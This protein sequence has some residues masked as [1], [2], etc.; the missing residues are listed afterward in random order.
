MRRSLAALTLLASM[1]FAAYGAAA[2]SVATT[3]G[4]PLAHPPGGSRSMIMH[5]VTC[6]TPQHLDY[7]V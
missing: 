2:P 6:H 3:D 7:G 5:S 4:S 1:L